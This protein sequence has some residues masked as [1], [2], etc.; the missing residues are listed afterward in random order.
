MLRLVHDASRLSAPALAGEGDRE[1]VEGPLSIPETYFT[2]ATAEIRATLSLTADHIALFALWATTRLRFTPDALTP[3]S[4]LWVDHAVFA[5]RL[6]R[7]PLS[8]DALAGSILAMAM[9]GQGY[10]GVIL[11]VALRP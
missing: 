2:E 3:R 6:G 5:D 7:E 4:T 11:G 1:A 10:K 8:P 9:P